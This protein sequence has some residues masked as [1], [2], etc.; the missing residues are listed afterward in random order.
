MTLASQPVGFMFCGVPLRV[1]WWKYFILA[2]AD[3]EGNFLLVK[4]YQYTTI[5]SVQ[6]LD[7]FTIPC[8]MVLACIVISDVTLT[9]GSFAR[10]VSDC[11]F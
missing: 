6:L 8:V 5:T 9:A 11:L 7:C 10:G 3:V 1:H 4:A 2:L